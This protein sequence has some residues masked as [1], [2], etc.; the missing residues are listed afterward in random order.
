M[1]S[2]AKVLYTA[3]ILS[4]G[5][6]ERGAVRSADGVLDLRL[7]SPGSGRIGTNPE[8]L[9]AAGWSASFESSLAIAARERGLDLPADTHIA[10]VVALELADDGYFLRVVF[11][12]G[13]KGVDPKIARALVDEAHRICPFSKATRGNISV[14]ISVS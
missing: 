6:R 8:Q 13:L 4:K 9:L 14:A 7:A 5:G 11:H 3:R 1:S 2:E 10:A 12:I